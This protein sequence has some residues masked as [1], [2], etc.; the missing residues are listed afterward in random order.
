VTSELARG[1]VAWADL[2]LTRGHEQF[3]RRPVLVVASEAF[4]ATMTALAIVVPATSSPRRWANRVPLRGPTGLSQPTWAITEQVRTIDRDRI[5][6]VVGGVDNA[7]L[8]DV[9]VWLRDFLGL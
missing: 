4:L 9:D 5:H 7:T 2:E 8:R 3:G 6:R 1:S